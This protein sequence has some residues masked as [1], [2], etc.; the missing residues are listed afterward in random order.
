MQESKSGHALLR[1]VKVLTEENEDLGRQQRETKQAAQVSS[2]KCCSTLQQS[3]ASTH[4]CM[5][6]CSLFEARQLC[7]STILSST[8]R[9]APQVA[10]V[11]LA[12]QHQLGSVATCK[13]TI[14][15]CYNTVLHDAFLEYHAMLCCAAQGAIAAVERRHA[16]ELREQLQDTRDLCTFKGVV[17]ILLPRRAVTVRSCAVPCC[18]G[19]HR[20]G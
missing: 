15:T 14:L 9:V 20:S 2:A 16:D 5:V 4:L 13:D 6:C 8:N 12:A 3:L 11:A 18:T 1:K 19:C 17:I 10:V 7:C